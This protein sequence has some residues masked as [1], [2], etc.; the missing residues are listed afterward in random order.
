[1]NNKHY[2]E[3]HENE[4][5]KAVGAGA[6]GGTHIARAVAQQSGYGST[7]PNRSPMK[8][9]RFGE[10]SPGES[11]MYSRLRGYMTFTRATTK[12]K[13]V[14]EPQRQAADESDIIVLI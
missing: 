2:K 6:G 5:K 7:K 12:G 3:E 11:F 8:W 10:E 4:I 13:A 9:V 14:T 1:M